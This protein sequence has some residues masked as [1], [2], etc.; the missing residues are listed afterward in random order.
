LA[1]GK[2][3]NRL[4]LATYIIKY[5]PIVAMRTHKNRGGDIHAKSAF[6]KY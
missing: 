3:A 1:T 4:D 6:E 5:Q 2:F